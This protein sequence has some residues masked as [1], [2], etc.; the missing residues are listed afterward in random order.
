MVSIL[1]QPHAVLL[2]VHFAS[3]AAEDVQVV[4]P[5]EV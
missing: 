1:R 4:F 3:H 5:F 2:Q